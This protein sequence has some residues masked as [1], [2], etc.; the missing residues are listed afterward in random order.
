M[1]TDMMN[2]TF[3]TICKHTNKNK[4][5]LNLGHASFCFTKEE[6]DSIDSYILPNS[7]AMDRDAERSTKG[8]EECLWEASVPSEPWPGEA[9]P[10][11]QPE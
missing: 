7:D 2:T 11:D 9:S 6:G 10:A 8:Q 5:T 1:K 4:H 3:Q